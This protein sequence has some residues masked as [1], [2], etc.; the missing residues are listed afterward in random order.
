MRFYIFDFLFH[1]KVF[2][3]WLIFVKCFCF[4]FL[5]YWS[6]D[7][8]YKLS[9]MNR[10]RNDTVIIYDACCFY[11]ILRFYFSITKNNYV[12]QKWILLI[13][14][15]SIKFTSFVN[16][17]KLENFIKLSFKTRDLFQTPYKCR[18]FNN[19]NKCM[20]CFATS[21]KILLD[22]GNNAL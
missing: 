19:G 13:V 7:P 11:Y 6:K 10:L 17:S 9:W 14:M 2:S 16:N 5:K 8:P 3:V 18:W 20:Y 15:R 1:W 22:L 12:F 4:S 21:E